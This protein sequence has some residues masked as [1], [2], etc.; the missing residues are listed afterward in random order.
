M[1][2]PPPPHAAL[3]GS[4]LGLVLPTQQRTKTEVVRGVFPSCSSSLNCACAHSCCLSSH[5]C[6]QQFTASYRC[7]DSLLVQ[8]TIHSSPLAKSPAG[9]LATQSY[10]WWFSMHVYIY[11][12]RESSPSCRYAHY[13]VCISAAGTASYAHVGGEILF[14]SGYCWELVYVRLAVQLTTYYIPKACMYIPYI[15]TKIY[16]Y[17]RT[18]IALD[19]CWVLGARSNYIVIGSKLSDLT[20][21]TLLQLMHIINPNTNNMSD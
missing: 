21:R 11:V 6:V 1:S 2:V 8:P 19:Q 14:R 4:P 18:Y 5:S 16:T 7:Q 12:Y 20:L 17:I 15:K 10:S 9:I 3:P 13:T